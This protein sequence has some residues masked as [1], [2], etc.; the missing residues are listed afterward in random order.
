[1]QC[2]FWTSFN[3]EALNFSYTGEFG[4]VYK[5]SMTDGDG[6]KHPVAVKTLKVS[7]NSFFNSKNSVVKKHD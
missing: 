3:N 5:G 6:K 2:L 1:M 7:G 4:D